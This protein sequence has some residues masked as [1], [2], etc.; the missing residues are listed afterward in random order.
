MATALEP[1]DL[2]RM[3]ATMVEVARVMIE[4]MTNRTNGGQHP[5]DLSKTMYADSPR[6]FGKDAYGVTI[7]IDHPAAG[8]YEFGSGLYGAKRAKY[9]I[10]PKDASVL[11]F[12]EDDWPNFKYI[13][14]SH[15]YPINGKFFLYHVEHPGIKAR[16]YIRPSLKARMNDMKK[17]IKR[18]F[19]AT[20]GSGK[21]ERIKIEVTI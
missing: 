17:L 9:L 21:L 18:D 3:Q 15:V 7:H 8:A 1:F 11:S 13:E 12:P 5:S 2:N 16:P 14:G 6:F 19:V 20:I 10:K 4:E